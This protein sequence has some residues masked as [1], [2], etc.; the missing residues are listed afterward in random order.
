MIDEWQNRFPYPRISLV[1]SDVDGLMAGSHFLAEGQR[2][3]I[4]LLD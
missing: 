3:A 1:A 2:L 4:G